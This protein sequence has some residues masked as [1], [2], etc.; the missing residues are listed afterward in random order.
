MFTS[1][2]IFTAAMMMSFGTCALYSQTSP[3]DINHDGV[4]NNADVQL[5]VNAAL[6]LA[7]CTAD[8]DGDGRCDIVD[9]QRVVN[10]ALGG[11]C[12]VTTSMGPLKA[13]TNPHYFVNTAGK[14]VLLTGSHTWDDFQDTDQSSSPAAFNFTSYVSFLT[15]HSQTAT[16]LWHKDLPT[17]CFWGAGGTWHMSPFP[18]LRPGPGTASDGQP[19]FDVTQFNQAYFDRLRSRAIQLQQSNI[20]AIVELFD[21]LGINYDRCGTTSPSGDGYPF[22]GVNNINGIDDGYTSGASGTGSMTMTAANAITNIQDAYVKKVI[23]TLHDLPNVLWEVSEEA[24]DNSTWWQNHMISLIHTY[25]LG[26]YGLQHPV[27]F[28]SLDVNGASDSTLYNSNADWVAPKS[29]ISPTS[30]CGTGSPACKVN[31]NDSD[32]S[33]YF[34]NM[35]DSN[36]N[37]V[38]QLVHNYIW[39]NFLAGSQVLF[40]DPYEIYWTSNNRNFCSSPS[41][42]VCS[43][44]DPKWN[45]LRDNLGYTATYANKMNLLAMTPQPSLSSTGF[46]LANA[47]ATGAEYLVYAPSGGTFTVNLSA[48]TRTMNVEWFNP[49]TGATTSGGTVAGGSS[50]R[51]FTPPFSGEAVLYL[52]DSA[53]HA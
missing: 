14:A 40:M 50:A 8:L 19:K 20:Y 13:T 49:S 30:S 9:V 34:V 3:C 51:S 36:F 29:Q 43:G 39:E 21:G 1:R 10:A 2:S 52:V 32:H 27:G 31:F 46:C 11:T 44:V 4:V 25:E 33:N 26:T 45:N 5:A 17:Y 16:I 12:L 37:I 53:G 23:D 7:S 42:G 18:W 35:M 28:P 38:P 24:P 48:T 41:N 22:T 6:G 47:I 15:S